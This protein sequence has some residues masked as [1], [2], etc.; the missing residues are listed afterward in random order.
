MENYLAE[1]CSELVRTSPDDEFTIRSLSRN[2]PK[3]QAICEDFGVAL[4]ALHRFQA[5]GRSEQARASEYKQISEDLRLE[6]MEYVSSCKA[7]NKDPGD[8]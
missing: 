4:N 5:Q 1:G 6:L 7:R 8:H 2:D 3:F